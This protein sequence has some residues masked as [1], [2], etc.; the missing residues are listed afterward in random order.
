M[1]QP[2]TIF[3]TG[4]CMVAAGLQAQDEAVLRRYLEG[5]EVAV[6]IDMP[7]DVNGIDIF[8]EKDPPVDYRRLGDHLKKY[9]TSLPKGTRTMI[10]KVHVKKDRIELQLGGGGYGTFGD[11]AR[12]PS[13][14]STSVSKSRRERD[15]ESRRDSASNPSRQRAIENELSRERSARRREEDRRRSGAA[16]ANTVRA[17]IIMDRR[18]KSGSRFNIRWDK[19]LPPDALTPEGL[20]VLVSSY[21]TFTGEG[22]GPVVHTS[23]SGSPRGTPDPLSLRKGMPETDV[24]AMFGDPKQRRL[25]H[26]DGMAIVDS[27]YALP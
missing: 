24:N 2:T 25:R 12:A 10:T 13:S 15:L 4:I 1:R 6:K 8:P 26:S 23:F 20:T 9:G 5:K 14:P 3:V 22:P 16:V 17:Q 19:Q 21:V 11:I 7:G 27:T 18:M